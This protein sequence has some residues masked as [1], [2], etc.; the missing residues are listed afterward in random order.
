[1][2]SLTATLTQ[3]VKTTG[4]NTLTGLGA[5]GGSS[6]NA[7]KSDKFG[8]TTANAASMGADLVHFKLYT[9]AASGSTTIDLTSVTDLAGSTATFARLKAWR[10]HLLKATETAPDGTA[11]TACSSILVGN[12]ASNAHL[13][14]LSVVLNGASGGS[15]LPA[16][17]INNGGCWS[18]SD[19]S[20]AGLVVDSSHKNV[21]ILNNDSGVSAQVLVCFIGGTS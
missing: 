3:N 20:A 9:I 14:G 1:M 13:L 19:D 16:K 2:N 6:P 21:K 18:D 12:A 8:S 17:T 15:P 10:I 5:V 11:G 7:T 4:Y